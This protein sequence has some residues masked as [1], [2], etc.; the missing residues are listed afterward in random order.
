[1]TLLRFATGEEPKRPDT[2]QE[3]IRAAANGGE[4]GKPLD[5][6]ANGPLRYRHVI[7]PV[8]STDDRIAFVV[9]VLELR[10]VDPDVH[11]EFELTN[12]TGA[13][14]EGRDPTLD[15]IVGCPFRQRW[16]V[17]TASSDHLPALHVLC[18]VARIHPA[19]VRA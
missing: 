13:T 11:G 9:Q 4:C 1:M 19:D 15:A 16:T 10:I 5:P 18:G 17:C 7:R 6:L 14:D 12:Q 2:G 8:V 3:E